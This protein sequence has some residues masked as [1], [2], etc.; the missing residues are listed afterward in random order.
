MSKPRVP[1]LEPLRAFIR[2][3]VVVQA[4]HAVAWI[5][6]IFSLGLG[7]SLVVSPVEVVQVPTF[8]ENFRFADPHIWGIGFVVLGLW[9]VVTLSS[10]LS[11][12]PLPLYGLGVLTGVWGLFTLPAVANGAGAVSAV[13]VYSAMAGICMVAATSISH[14]ER[15]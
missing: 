13:W 12:A 1:S 14:Q 4:I 2:R 6:L 10:N 7:V 3:T 5:L 8:V 11:G 15:A 9:G